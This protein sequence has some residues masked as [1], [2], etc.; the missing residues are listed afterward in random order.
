M[1]QLVFI[2]L[3]LF[4]E[5]DLTV[6]MV[7]EIK[8]ANAIF[9]EMYTSLM[10]GFSM[11]RLEALVGKKVTQVSRHLLE[12]E[13]GELILKAAKKGKVV[14][15]VPGDPLIAT[16]HVD[17]RIRAV[18]QGVAT[19]ILHGASIVSAVVGLSG[20][21]NYKF[22]RSVTIPFPQSTFTSTTPY[23]VITQ[24]QEMGLHTLCYL[25]IQAK[26]QRYMTIKEG[27]EVLLTLES[28]VENQVISLDTVV[29]GVARAGSPDPVVK[30]GSIKEVTNVEFGPPPHSLIIPGDLHFMEADALVT[31]AEGPE[32]LR[33]KAR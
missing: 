8:T 2:G 9:V 20:L 21:Q 11:L 32:Q 28:R 29:L 15:L 19:R 4:D 31:L 30:A 26:A 1:G 27:L 3:G 25:D 24:N 7:E 10:P 18:Q 22:G 33:K 12:D 17:L 5:K 16:T 6:R 23:E 14:F 13:N